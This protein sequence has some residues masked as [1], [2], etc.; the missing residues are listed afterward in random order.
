MKTRRLN[1]LLLLIV[2]LFANIT[3]VNAINGYSIKPTSIVQNEQVMFIMVSQ[4][5]EDFSI[6]L[7]TETNLSFTDGITTYHATLYSVITIAS[8]SSKTTLFCL[9]SVPASFTSGN[10][11]PTISYHGTTS[12]QLY[13]Q[14]LSLSTETVVVYPN[15]NTLSSIVDMIPQKITNYFYSYPFLVWMVNT[16]TAPIILSNNTRL[17]ISDNTYLYA[18]AC[19]SAPL[20]LTANQTTKV[21]FQYSVVQN[22]PVGF[23]TTKLTVFSDSFSQSLSLGNMVVQVVS[24]YVN[25]IGAGPSSIN[26]SLSTQANDTVAIT[27]GVSGVTYDFLLTVDLNTGKSGAGSYASPSFCDIDGDGDYDFFSGGTWGYN[28]TGPVTFSQNTGTNSSPQWGKFNPIIQPMLTSQYSHPAFVDIDNDSDFDMFVGDESGK[29]WLFRNTGSMYTAKWNNGP[30]E[31]PGLSI[32]SAASPCFGDLDGD[33]DN[34][35]L[36]GCRN[37]NIWVAENVGNNT[38]PSYTTAIQYSST[39]VSNYSAPALVDIDNDGDCDLFIGA[40]NG[41]ITYVANTGNINIPLWGALVS[42]FSGISVGTRAVPTFVDID[43]DVDYDLFVGNGTT[44]IKFY[45]NQGTSSSPIFVEEL[46]PLTY[47]EPNYKPLNV[48]LLPNYQSLLSN[49]LLVYGRDVNGGSRIDMNFID[50]YNGCDTTDIILN[51]KYSGGIYIRNRGNPITP[52]GGIGVGVGVKIRTDIIYDNN[53]EASITSI[54]SSLVSTYRNQSFD[55]GVEMKCNKNY[56]LGIIYI[57][58]GKSYHI[59]Q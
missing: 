6:S 16:S 46:S 30:R 50:S 37:G 59:Y 12:G 40:D 35:L 21:E 29:I 2:L 22:I 28:G 31:Y 45:R 15:V 52:E 55:F 14:T 7:D 17:S 18:T 42:N 58:P 25:S 38:V 49:P 11:I 24:D 27:A 32:G 53:A 36:I 9:E 56:T 20:T 43:H 1:F 3:I 33:G 41:F 26:K 4:N 51:N 5:T 34:D 23:Y 47:M 19:I 8:G 48:N 54:H 44:A 10:Y 13:T 39:S 57:Q